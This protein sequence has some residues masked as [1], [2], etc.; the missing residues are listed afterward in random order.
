MTFVQSQAGVPSRCMIF[1]FSFSRINKSRSNRD[2]LGWIV[3]IQ[4][5]T[6]NGKRRNIKKTEYDL[7]YKYSQF[8]YL[9]VTTPF[10]SITVLCWGFHSVN[11]SAATFLE[12]QKL[13]YRVCILIS[14]KPCTGFFGS[15][16]FLSFK[17]AAKLTAWCLDM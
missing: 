1:R 11:S 12:S 7:Q 13:N 5:L 14:L 6:V 15:L 10:I 4:Y 17:R 16:R 8:H 2:L 3:K 9:I